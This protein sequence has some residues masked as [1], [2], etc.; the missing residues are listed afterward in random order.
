[1]LVTVTKVRCNV[2]W[3]HG[4]LQHVRDGVDVR[5]ALLDLVNTV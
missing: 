3:I 5:I 4:E 1:M 2:L